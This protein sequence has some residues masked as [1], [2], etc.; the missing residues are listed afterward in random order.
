VEPV[1]DGPEKDRIVYGEFAGPMLALLE[2]VAPK[3]AVLCTVN[4]SGRSDSD[5][6]G[7]AGSERVVGRAEPC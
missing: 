5:K 2:P 4:S 1:A 3:R 6:L 7:S